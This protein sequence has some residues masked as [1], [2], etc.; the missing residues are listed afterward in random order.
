MTPG[1]APAQ[2]SRLTFAH[3]KTLLALVLFLPALVDSIAAPVAPQPQ[4]GI[5]ATPL[6]DALID[7]AAS[8]DWVDNAERPLPNPAALRQIV[9]TQTTAPGGGA[10]VYGASPQPGIRHLRLGFTSTVPVGTVLVRGGGQLS[11][12]RPGAPYPGNLADESQWLPAQRLVNGQLSTD[13]V[14]PEGYA[15]WILPPATRTRALRFTSTAQLTDPKFQGSLGGVYLLAARLA[16]LA[17]QAAVIASANEAAASLLT[18]EKHNDWRTWDNGPDFRH[19]VTTS[20]PETITLAWPQ[21]VSISGIALLWAGFNGFDLQTLVGPD[22]LSPQ[23]APESAWQPVGRPVQTGSQYPRQ[24]G[25]DWLDFGKTI[26]TR[27]LRLRITATTDESH[28]PHLAGKTRNGTRVWLG[29]IM[30][31]SPLAANM[32]LTAFKSAASPSLSAV[33]SLAGNPIPGSQP[34]T[35]QPQPPIPVHFTLAAAGNVTLVIDDAQGNRVRNLVA[36]TYFPAGPNTVYWDGSDD[37]GRNYDAALHGVYLIPTNFVAPGHYQ[38]RGLVHQAIELHYEFSAYNG[39]HPAW[40]TADGKGGWLTNHTPPSAALFLPADK[41]PGGKPLVYL[42]SYVSEGGSALAWVDLDGNKQGG[43]GWIGGAWT[44]APYLAADNGPRADPNTFAYVAAI[45]R[46][47]ANKDPQ[48]ITGVVRLTALT[49]GG[50]K[51]VVTF[52]YDPG[53]SLKF[54]ALSKPLWGQQIG[55]LAVRNGLAVVSLTA[56]DQLLLVNT[57]TGRVLGQANVPSPRGLAFDSQGNLL[58]LSGKQLLRFR[59][60]SNFESGQVQ[61][62]QLSSPAAVIASTLEDPAGITL[63]KTGTIYISDRGSSHQ[64]KIFTPEGR[65]LRAIGHPGAPQAGPYDPLHMNNPRGLAIDANN[66][67][68]VAEED[69]Q[70]KRVSLWSLDGPPESKLLKAF[71]GPAEY[72]GGGTL[73]PQDKTRFYY[74]GMEFKLD[75]QTGADTLN[76]VLYRPTADGLPAQLYVLPSTAAYANGH[77]YFSN[78]YSG[79]EITGVNLAFIYLDEGGVLHPVA[80]MGR[81]NDWPLLATDAFRQSWPAGTDLASQNPANFVLFSWSDTNHNGRVDSDEVTFQKAVSGSVTLMPDMALVNAYVDGN[82]VRY[83]PRFTQA[84]VPVY[85][86]RSGATIV[87]GAQRPRSDGGG[88]AL[89]STQETILTTAPTPFGPEGVG[90]VFLDAAKAPHRWSYPS[91]WPGLHPSHS[92]PVADR[93]GELVGTTRLLGGFVTP[94]NSDAG[95]LW[96]INGNYGNAYLFTADGLFV[97]QLFQDQRTGKPWSMPIAQRNMLLNAV[98]LG[99]ENFLPSIAQTSD[100][101]IYI[102]DG[103][104]TSLVRVDGLSSIR[105]IPPQPLE[106]T[107]ADMQKAKG[108]VKLAEVS[109]QNASGPKVLH[110]SMR[111]G[112]APQLKDLASALNGA[113]WATID[114]RINQV[115]WSGKAD[116]AQAAIMIAGG[117]LFASY[118]TSEPNLLVN[119]NNVANA[120]FKTGGAL[121]LML[122][123]NAGADPKRTSPAVGD[124]RLLVY[125]TT[126]SA[127]IQNHA[128]LYRAVVP[129]TTRP[130]PFS[131]PAQTITLDQVIDVSNDVELDST[132]GPPGTFS[133]S[134]PLAAL[135]LKPAAGQTIKADIGILRGNG[136]QTL[137]RVYWSN[138]ATGITSDVPSEAE[139]TPELWGQ[140]IFQPAP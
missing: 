115:G 136:T 59:L 124:M 31:L 132:D 37:L 55:G 99:G 71:Y 76:S 44:G 66:H 56:V 68:W 112:L 42:G 104:R 95:R 78:T 120:P 121:D 63:D 5:F 32:Q 96:A 86:I 50:D 123:V 14:G 75:W 94:P 30:A 64:V 116:L 84:G 107:D 111:S 43:R 93:P 35:N 106:I 48:H 134:I 114:S 10:L 67:L 12:L 77:R 45:W 25:P 65:F 61:P 17:P 85:D 57:A 22:T 18:D 130:V 24:L 21:S 74:H 118:R 90:G 1:N 81:A 128:L 133:F 70:P 3:F 117:R 110:V 119:A 38:V 87:T 135:G 52:P 138:K 41:A 140:W 39:G 82:A 89:Y 127:G 98:T 4:S 73:D 88:Q 97:S 102:D 100:G 27:A 8:A 131:S 6:S 16:N 47:E 126:T 7:N 109:R 113:D 40:E 15:L 108:F 23:T 137:Q 13:P 20:T 125:Q 62:S 60:P 46:D 105:R 49:S 36:D 103:T 11:V 9:W 51:P 92:A 72:G 53:A 129:G 33:N 101:N 54:D 139:L 122:G 80:A 29:E 91:L 69:F 28:H 58:V 83:L 2:R 19:P 79:R 26:Q 34:V